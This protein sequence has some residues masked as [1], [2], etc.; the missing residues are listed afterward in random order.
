MAERAC[1]GKLYAFALV[2]VQ[3]CTIWADHVD[4]A[5]KMARQLV[6]NG[7]SAGSREGSLFEW[8]ISR[9]QDPG[10]TDGVDREAEA[11]LEE[12]Q[13]KAREVRVKLDH[14][15]KEGAVQGHR[16]EGLWKHGLP[17]LTQGSANASAQPTGTCGSCGPC[18]PRA[19]HCM[20]VPCI[21]PH[22]L[23]RSELP[24]SQMRSP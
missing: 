8:S 15:W 13:S 3:W 1:W 22:A 4:L 20:P 7:L 9:V 16:W 11:I 10:R 17:I 14:R 5:R 21:T 24:D 18:N 19:T 23:A 6:F 2:A 12:C